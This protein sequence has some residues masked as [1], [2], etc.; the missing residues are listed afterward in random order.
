[1]TVLIRVECDCCGLG[2]SAPEGTDPD[3][4][5]TEEGLEQ[6]VVNGSLL[7]AHRSCANEVARGVHPSALC[8]LPG[9]ATP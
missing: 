5:R 2:T 9:L 4:L 7:D 3:Q 1:M 8:G 6:I